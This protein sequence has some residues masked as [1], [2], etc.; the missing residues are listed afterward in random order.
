VKKT[1]DQTIEVLKEEL[2]MWVAE[3]KVFGVPDYR[4][5]YKDALKLAIGVRR[6]A[7]KVSK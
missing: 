1:K 4:R 6:A 7:M 3:S 2:A 5:G